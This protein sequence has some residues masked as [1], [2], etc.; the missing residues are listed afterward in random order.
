MSNKSKGMCSKKAS[1]YNH[2]SNLNKTY[3]RVTHDALIRSHPFHHYAR[4]APPWVGLHAGCYTR[5]TDIGWKHSPPTS[6]LGIIRPLFP[7]DGTILLVSLPALFSPVLAGIYTWTAP[8][9]LTWHHAGNTCTYFYAVAPVNP[10]TAA[11]PDAANNA[12]S[13][14]YLCWSQF[15]DNAMLHPDDGDRGNGHARSWQCV[16][17]MVINSRPLPYL[18]C[19]DESTLFR[20]A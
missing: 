6:G 11:Y 13:M 3:T 1:K 18:P 16:H 17:A 8:G 15:H 2:D 5:A 20:D 14:G 7:V 4:Q 12:G 9:Q 19:T 10:I